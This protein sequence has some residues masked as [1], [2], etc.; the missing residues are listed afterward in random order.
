MVSISLLAKVQRRK[1]LLDGDLKAD[2]AIA[3][4]PANSRSKNRDG[5][6]PNDADCF[7]RAG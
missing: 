1:R 6:A 7:G 2:G 5:V 4:L 3:L